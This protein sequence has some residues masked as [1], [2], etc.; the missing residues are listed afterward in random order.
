MSVPQASSLTDVHYPDNDPDCPGHFKGMETILEERSSDVRALKA[1]CKTAFADCN[2]PSPTGQCCCHRILYNEPDFV[3][4]KGSL[5][6]LVEKE[7]HICD[8]YPKFHPELNF[9]EQYWGAAKYNY[10]SC[11]PSSKIDDMEKNM[12]NAL[13]GVPL[14]LIRRSVQPPKPSHCLTTSLL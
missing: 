8:F 5:Q 4:Q 10:R 1:Q 2:D 12:T 11:P 9:I 3:H 7:G 13:G 14:L 6:E